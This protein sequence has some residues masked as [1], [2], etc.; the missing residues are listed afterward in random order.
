VEVAST[1]FE[2]LVVEVVVV[3]AK[4][5]GLVGVVV[6]VVVGVVVEVWLVVVELGC[7]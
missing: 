4:E 2:R 1:H 6:L 3:A 5:R 7:S